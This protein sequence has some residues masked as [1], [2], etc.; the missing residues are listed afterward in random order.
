MRDRTMKDVDVSVVMC[1]CN[2]AEMVRAALESLFALRPAEGLRHEI[3]VVD[4]AS[5]DATADVVRAMAKDAPVP[6]RVVHEATPGG[7]YAHN[8][9]IEAAAGEWVAWF[10]DD[11]V[12]DERWLFALLDTARR[13]DAKSV[14]GA[15]KLRFLDGGEHHLHRAA[16]RLLGE[17]NGWPDERP[18]TRKEGP[19]SGNQLLHRSVFERIGVYD[20]A[21]NRRGYDTDLYRRIRLAGFESWYTPDAV[22]HHLTPPARLELDY[23]RQTSLSNGWCFAERDRTEWGRGAAWAMTALRLGHAAAVHVPRLAWARL[24]GD[25]D[26]VLDARCELWRAQGYARTALAPIVPPLF[27]RAPR[28]SAAAATVIYGA[29]VV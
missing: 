12:A 27:N 13:R 22:V 19:G 10:D 5:T 21:Y 4:N 28:G 17:S 11:E 23:L 3:L 20:V 18:Y 8:R 26:G 25:A 6:L 29:G 1:T 7:A 15:V 2:R 14:G 9:G 16:R 24:R